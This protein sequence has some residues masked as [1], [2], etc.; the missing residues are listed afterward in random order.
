M[1]LRSVLVSIDVTVLIF[2]IF[3]L[4]SE[5]EDIAGVAERPVSGNVVEPAEVA[6]AI[7]EATRDRTRLL[8]PSDE[9]QMAYDLSRSDPAGFEAIMLSTMDAD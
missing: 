6:E 3:F 8:L 5:I 1:S 9:S 4:R 7:Y 2:C